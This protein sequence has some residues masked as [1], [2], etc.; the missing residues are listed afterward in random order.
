MLPECRLFS[1]KGE[2]A[3]SKDLEMAARLAQAVAAAGGRAYFVGG[4]V[5]DQL[6]GKEGKDIDIEV[7]GVLPAQLESILDGLG[8]RTVMGI[9]FGVY[10]LKHFDLDIAMPRSETK[11][12]RGHRDFTVDVDPFLGTEKAARRRDFTINALMQD[13]LTG[14]V[15]DHYGGLNDLKKGIIRHV[16]DASFG[17]DPLRVLRAAQFA[18]RFRFAVAP[19]TVA[20]CSKMELSA[21]AGERVMEELNK[22]LLKAE[23]PSIFFEQLWQMKQ[24]GYW[25]PE[26][27]A[28]IGVEQEPR[29]HPEGDV[30][31]HTML[32]LDQAAALREKA[33]NPRGL[34]LAALC[35]DF[36]KPATTRV[37]EGRIRSIGHENAGAPLAEGFI[38][39][40]NNEVR[41]KKYVTNMVQLHMRPNALVAMGSGKKAY[42]KLFDEA[43]EPADLLLLAKADH[44]GRGGSQDYTDYGMRLT[45][46]LEVYRELMNHPSVSGEDLIRAGVKP[47][48]QMGQAIA[49]AHKLHLSG[50]EHAAALTQTLAWLREQGQ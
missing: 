38:S 8:E 5:R 50:V 19:E 26:V 11:T 16:W 41:L 34:L 39:R 43:L 42:M 45:S 46:M 30:Y 35:H 6:M 9:S 48:K 10:G 44:C 49:Y 2:G 3:M 40:M 27:E 12:G 23:Q 21:L 32:V 22:A 29:F 18:A 13:V 31:T 28:L 25:F 7:H 15:I 47:G 4:Y 24:L 20:L 37:Q 33:I 36:G 14:E 17:E 1:E